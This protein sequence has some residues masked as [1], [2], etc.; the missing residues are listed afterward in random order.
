MAG[1]TA[2]AVVATRRFV[3]RGNVWVLCYLAE[4]RENFNGHCESI[5]LTS[6]KGRLN[7]SQQAGSI[8]HAEPFHTFP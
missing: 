8:G 6:P 3:Q 2:E 1:Q 7:A 4:A 5:K